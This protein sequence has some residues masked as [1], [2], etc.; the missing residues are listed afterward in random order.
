MPFSPAEINTMEGIARSI[1]KDI[2]DTEKDPIKYRS[3][4]KG[5][6]RKRTDFAGE[7]VISKINGA[8]GI[9]YVNDK[10]RS[11]F[12]LYVV[13]DT[14]S[15]SDSIPRVARKLGIAIPKEIDDIFGYEYISEALGK[16]LNTYIE[17]EREK[18]ASEILEAVFN[19][20]EN[21]PRKNE[22][23]E[24]LREVP[25]RM[26]SSHYAREN[27]DSTKKK[28]LN[29]ENH[30]LGEYVLFMLYHVPFAV[31]DSEEAYKRFIT[32]I[33]EEFEIN[34]PAGFNNIAIFNDVSAGIGEKAKSP[35][36]VCRV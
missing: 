36:Y 5:T 12:T 6:E 8:D 20:F 7:E 14:E 1:Y 19:D 11:D 32:N 30:E 35:E 2:M 13:Y 26:Y 34:I 29:L 25:D 9:P 18:V 4:V 28:I 21:T 31:N 27:D 23:I 24:A 3:F 33:V 10:A 16:M 15:Y 22:L 17:E